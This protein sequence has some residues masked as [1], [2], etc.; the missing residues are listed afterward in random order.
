M[1]ARCT[2]GFDLK[3]GPVTKRRGLGCWGAA[4]W[5]AISMNLAIARS[6]PKQKSQQPRPRS[7]KP[8][9][10]SAPRSPILFWPDFW[11]GFS[12]AE[13]QRNALLLPCAL[14]RT[15]VSNNA[16]CVVS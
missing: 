11:F 12:S 4:I 13:V 14:S 8:S 1:G 9:T 3:P 16:I 7:V 6:H 15:G 5:L 2:L 10:R